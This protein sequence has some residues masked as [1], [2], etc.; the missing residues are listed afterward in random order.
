MIGTQ[1]TVLVAHWTRRIDG[2]DY[3]SDNESDNEEM[4][5]AHSDIDLGVKELYSAEEAGRCG[6]IWRCGRDGN[7]LE[8]CDVQVALHGHIYPLPWRAQCA[9]ERLNLTPFHTCTCV[10]TIVD[11]VGRI[12]DLPVFTMAKLSPERKSY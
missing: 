4:C 11:R 5:E 10:P 2:S 7:V 3:E 9:G 8:S 12:V 6:L 1:T